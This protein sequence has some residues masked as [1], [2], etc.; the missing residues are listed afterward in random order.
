MAAKKKEITE[1]VVETEPNELRITFTTMAFNVSSVLTALE[2]EAFKR[3]LPISSTKIGGFL[4][5]TYGVV[6]KGSH[7]EV[8]EFEDWFKEN[9][10]QLSE[11]I[12]TKALKGM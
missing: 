12:F 4:D 9:I 11:T 5:Q 6:V 7:E 10:G 3:N 2:E 1:E 8:N